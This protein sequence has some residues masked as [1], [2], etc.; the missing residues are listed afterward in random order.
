MV[1]YVWCMLVWYNTIILVLYHTIHTKPYRAK[2]HMAPRR[3][4]LRILLSI[5]NNMESFG[6]NI[7]AALREL[8]VQVEYSLDLL[9]PRVSREYHEARNLLPNADVCECSPSTINNIVV[10][11]A[12]EPRHEYLLDYMTYRQCRLTKTKT[13]KGMS[14]SSI[15]GVEGCDGVS[16]D[17]CALLLIG[18][19]SGFLDSWISSL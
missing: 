4:R 18:F 17:E 15:F 19:K 16:K 3:H 1:W 2:P 9:D 13:S 7:K 8:K 5:W 11:R 12:H 14:N 10:G 6:E